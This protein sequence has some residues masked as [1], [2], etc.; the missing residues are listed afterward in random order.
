MV[1]PA[2]IPSPCYNIIMW[3]AHAQARQVTSVLSDY[4]WSLQIL[5]SK[6]GFKAN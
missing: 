6:L 4:V 3:T 1:T 2:N 5:Q